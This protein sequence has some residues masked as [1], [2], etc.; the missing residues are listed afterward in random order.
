MS[1]KTKQKFR[2][3]TNEFITFDTN[4]KN[5]NAIAFGQIVKETE[6]AVF[7]NYEI[8]PIFS[9]GNNGSTNYNR[10]AWLPKSVLTLNEV[11]MYTVKNWF[12]SKIAP[13]SI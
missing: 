13:F 4:A 2:T 9:N 5:G 10:A 6:K 12:L 7:I 1:H 8:V 11:G 3:M